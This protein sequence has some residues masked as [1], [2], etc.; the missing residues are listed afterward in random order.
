MEGNVAGLCDTNYKTCAMTHDDNNTLKRKVHRHDGEK[1]L[2]YG[3][4]GTR[5][6]WGWG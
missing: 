4:H 5:V 6:P 2:W 3:M 1:T